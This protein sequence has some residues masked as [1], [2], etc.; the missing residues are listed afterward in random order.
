MKEISR[1]FLV[2]DTAMEQRITRAKARIAAAEVPFETPDAAR[3]R[4]SAWR[5]WPRSST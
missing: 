4:P 5:R 3:S 2:G 1:A